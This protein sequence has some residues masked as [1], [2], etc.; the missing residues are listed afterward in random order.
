MSSRLSP[1]CGIK[2]TDRIDFFQAIPLYEGTL[3]NVLT[4]AS[5]TAPLHASRAKAPAQLILIDTAELAWQR[6]AERNRIDSRRQIS[7]ID[8]TRCKSGCGAGS[9]S[10]PNGVRPPSVVLRCFDGNRTP[11]SHLA[12][13][14]AALYVNEMAS[15][16]RLSGEFVRQ[17]DPARAGR[18][19][20]GTTEFWA[21]AVSSL[22]GAEA[23]AERIYRRA[24]AKAQVESR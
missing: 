4:F 1:S 17:A 24:L 13:S 7:L 19:R 23:V 8:S 2:C 5:D 15:M 6:A 11:G 18:H 12:L 14:R 16:W 20:M 10:L 21:T 22:K 9:N 3:I